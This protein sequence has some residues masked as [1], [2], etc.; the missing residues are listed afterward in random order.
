MAQFLSEEFMSEA[1]VKLNEHAG[2]ANAIS[3][4]TLG[5]Q[6]DVSDTPEGELPYY[7]KIGDGAA[8][9]ARGS[10]DDADVTIAN[11]YETSVGIS[12]GEVNTQ[13]AFMTGQLK[14]SGN[15]AM[16]MM[17]QAVFNQFTASLSDTDLEY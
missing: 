7:L 2:F 15:M 8:T 6:F 1:T 4:V 3:N 17:N 5:V 16:L 9:M 13:M 10:L 11:T 12:K 14:V